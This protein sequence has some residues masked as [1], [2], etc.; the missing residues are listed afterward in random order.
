[1]WTGANP[2]VWKDSSP[3]RG[4]CSA[5]WA[6]VRQALR[7]PSERIRKPTS[8]SSAGS[9]D[10][11]ATAPAPSP[12]RTHVRRSSQSSQR[13]SWSAPMTSTFS[14]TPPRMNWAAVIRANRKPLQAAVRSKATA[15]RAPM[16][17]WT[18]GAVPNRSSG[19]EVASRMRSTSSAAQ[20][21]WARAARAASAARLVTVSP[22]P[23]TRRAA[24]P[25][26]LRIQS[27][28]VSTRSLSWSFVMLPAG[29]ARPQPTRAMPREDAVVPAVSGPIGTPFGSQVGS[30]NHRCWPRRQSPGR[31]HEDRPSRHG[32]RRSGPA[33]GR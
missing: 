10:C 21:A 28:V 1:M 7:L 27:S 5:T 31:G 22:G 12:K 13:L 8:P 9:Q 16:A 32:W 4:R 3:T 23:A 15:R 24:I 17:A 6:R 2:P 26:R 30:V 19:L 29:S 14:I 33:A 11:R 18:R 25:V 20:P